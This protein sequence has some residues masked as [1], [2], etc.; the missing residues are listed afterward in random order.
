MFAW[1]TAALGKGQVRFLEP[2]IAQ[3]FD[4]SMGKGPT[5]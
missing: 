4:Y 5:S 2:V 3:V 1:Q